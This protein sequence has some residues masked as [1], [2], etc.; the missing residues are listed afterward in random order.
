MTWHPAPRSDALRAALAAADADRAARPE[1]YSLDP[2]RIAAAAHR[3]D[4]DRF[5]DGWRD[6]LAQYLGSATEDGRLNSLGLGMVATTAVGRL[7]A[8][9]AMSRFEEAHPERLRAP[10]VP[11]IVITGGWR[12]GTTFLFRLLA[13]DP[14][15]RAPLPAELASPTRVALMVDDER[16]AYID[17]SAPRHE[18]LYALNPEL[19]A[20]HDSGCWL[21]EECGLG[22]GTDLRNW[23]FTSTTRL[24]GYA[25][26]LA[27]EDLGPSYRNYRKVLQALGAGDERTW[28]LKAPPH[29]AE[30]PS[31]VAAFPGAVVV[32]LHRD[33][34]E[35]IAS[36]AS[37][38]AVFRSSYSDEVDAFDVGAFQ[39]AQTELWLR[40]AATFR[41]DPAT[42]ATFVDLQ[43]HDLVRNPATAVAMVYAAAGLEPPPDLTGFVAAFH[44]TQPRHAHGTHRY[45]AAD[46]GLDEHELRARFA[47]VEPVSGS[48]A[49]AR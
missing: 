1:H 11:P 40:R 5:D 19:R 21:P 29:T 45:T 48:D 22:M 16:R 41:A 26:W 43:Y 28:V 25:R 34:V 27:D 4:D 9:A 23:A 31:L 12:T 8:G 32:H 15:L 6:G 35:T 13:T 10:L 44:A 33:I 39:A 3:S 17:A 2:D 20:I 7:R 46:F 37:L 38:F 49:G 14:R 47:F 42:D 30:L 24:D 36:G 18:M